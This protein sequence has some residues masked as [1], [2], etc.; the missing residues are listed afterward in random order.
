[1]SDRN[2]LKYQVFA[3]FQREEDLETIEYAAGRQV[4]QPL[5]DPHTADFH[6]W[7][8]Q[9]ASVVAQRLRD[10]GFKATSFKNT[11]TVTATVEVVK[12][13]DLK[14]LEAIAGQ[15]LG[16]GKTNPGDQLRLTCRSWQEA[17]RITVAARHIGY[18]ASSEMEVEPYL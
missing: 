2:K 10:A 12:G 15:P 6:F 17:D 4:N 11:P 3:V 14:I 18:P 8:H 5:L 7:T 9:E 16:F 1:M 13:F